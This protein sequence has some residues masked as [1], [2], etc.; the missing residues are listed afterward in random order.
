MVMVV[1]SF[2]SSTHDVEDSQH[3]Q[4]DRSE[5]DIVTKSHD[6]SFHSGLATLVR[7]IQ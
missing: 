4:Y 5:Q 3:N 2:M 1:D 6:R 7:M